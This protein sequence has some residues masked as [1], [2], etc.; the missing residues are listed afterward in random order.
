[1]AR[2]MAGRSCPYSRRRHDDGIGPEQAGDQRINQE[3]IL[4]H[5]HVHARPHHGVGE[6]FQDFVGAV[7][8]DEVGRVH[9]QFGRQLLFEIKGVAVGVKVQLP[10]RGL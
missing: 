9:G 6:K 7:A 8:Q 1:M 5:H 4:R 10:G 2:S 3:A